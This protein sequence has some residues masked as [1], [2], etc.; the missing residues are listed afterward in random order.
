M[1][2]ALAL[3]KT[4]AAY[5]AS[6][7][8]SIGSIIE[9]S[10]FSGLLTRVDRPHAHQMSRERSHQA[11]RVGFLTEPTDVIGRR[12]D[13]RHAIMD[14]GDQ[15][16]RIRG[17]D[18]KGPNATPKRLRSCTAPGCLAFRADEAAQTHFYVLAAR[19]FALDADQ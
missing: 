16:V 9:G 8:G 18:G 11:A 17:D 2:V 13:D 4:S 6:V 3:S 1:R 10:S 5:A 15:L 7:A 12:K 19:A 14:V